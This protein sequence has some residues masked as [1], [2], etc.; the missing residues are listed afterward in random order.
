[1]MSKRVALAGFLHETNTFA[2]T[3]ALFSDFLQGGGY[4]PMSHGD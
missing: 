4:M 2:P 1:M 3:K